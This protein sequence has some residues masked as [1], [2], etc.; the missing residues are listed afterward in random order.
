VTIASTSQFYDPAR[1]GWATELLKRFGL[2]PS[3][4]PEMVPAGTRLGGIRPEV[5][6]ETGLEPDTTVFA[7]ASHDTASAVAAVPAE[8]QH[9]CYIS[10]GVV[11]DGVELRRAPQ[12]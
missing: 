3:I 2:N 8:G 9:W 7:T 11:P 6:Q 1:R 4:L 10:S 12:P 5:A